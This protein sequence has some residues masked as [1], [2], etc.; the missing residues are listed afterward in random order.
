MNHRMTVATLALM[1]LLLSSYLWFWKIGMLGDLACG[2]GGCETVQLGSYGSVAGIPVAFLGVLGYAGLLGVSI[3][4][5]QPRWENNR[6]P[7]TWLMMLSG[8]GVAFSAYLTYLEA[9]VIHA[10]CRWCLVSAALI[11]AV[12]A[13]SLVGFFRWRPEPSR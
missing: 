4:G 12:F 1:G 7:T 10:W 6:G 3:I 2:T 5:V 8:V 9:F 11:V 13:A